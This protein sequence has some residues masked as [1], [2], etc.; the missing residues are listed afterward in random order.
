VVAKFRSQKLSKV[1]VETKECQ[2]MQKTQ[3][4]TKAK[5]VALAN[6]NATSADVSG[7]VAIA[8][9]INPKNVQNAKSIVFR[10][11]R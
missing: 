1:R 8:M 9:P 5:D 7:R 10:R 3:R 11:D 2:R 6:T 4:R